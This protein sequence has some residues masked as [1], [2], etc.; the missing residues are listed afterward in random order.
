MK[1]ESPPPSAPRPARPAVSVWR[2]TKRELLVCCG[3][4][5]REVPAAA[6]RCQPSSQA[7]S[8]LRAAAVAAQ[9]GS[10]VQSLSRAASECT[11]PAGHCHTTLS[12]SAPPLSYRRTRDDSIIEQVRLARAP[13]LARAGPS[14]RGT[15][16]PTL[17]LPLGGI[18]FCRSLGLW[19][20][21][22]RSKLWHGKPW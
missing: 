3:R 6:A 15:G 4:A 2:P 5:G 12:R 1:T 20:C 18:P 7:V 13:S 21:Q 16:E 14:Q 19:A 10:R 8:G 17:D 9:V 11:R 22:Q